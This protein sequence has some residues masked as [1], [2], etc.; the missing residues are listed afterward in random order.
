MRLRFLEIVVYSIVPHSNIEMWI[1]KIDFEIDYSEYLRICSRLVEVQLLGM[2][3][4]RI[5]NSKIPNSLIGYEADTKY[6]YNP[7]KLAIWFESI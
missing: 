3:Q 2:V 5:A 6:V 1:E 7:M 4:H